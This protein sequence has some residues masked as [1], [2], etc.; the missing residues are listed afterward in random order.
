MSVWPRARVFHCKHGFYYWTHFI[1]DVWYP[2]NSPSDHTREKIKNALDNNQMEFMMDLDH[3]VIVRMII[4]NNPVNPIAFE[5]VPRPQ[6]M[7]GLVAVQ[8]MWRR[9]VKAERKMALMMGGHP[10]LGAAMNGFAD[11][12]LQEITRFM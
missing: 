12:L 9:W 8:R 2:G 5:V 7:R 10:R 1:P 6:V 4:L 3:G 11:E